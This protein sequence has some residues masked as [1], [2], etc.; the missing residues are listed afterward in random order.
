M[1]EGDARD[2]WLEEFKGLKVQFWVCPDGHSVTDHR[3]PPRETVRW[4]NGVATC[5]T[6]GCMRTSVGG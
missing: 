3:E 6:P 4:I 1:A 2:D 5:T